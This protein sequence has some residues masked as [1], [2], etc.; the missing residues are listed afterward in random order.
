M[1]SERERERERSSYSPGGAVVQCNADYML[2]HTLQH[3]LQQALQHRS[4]R[5]NL[6]HY[7]GYG[8]ATISRLLKIIG[9]FCKR[10][11]EKR[12]Y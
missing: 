12:L 7:T 3:A 5:S 1:C 9:L 8:V 4:V 11:L 2:Q 10:A 6:Y